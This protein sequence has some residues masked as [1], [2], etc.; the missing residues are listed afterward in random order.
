[1]IFEKHYDYAC[2]PAPRPRVMRGHA[3]RDEKYQAWKT[4]VGLDWRQSHGMLTQRAGFEWYEVSIRISGPMRGDLDNYAKSVL[5]ALVG[6]QAI[7][8]DAVK[9]LRGLHVEYC[10]NDETCFWVGITG[11]SSKD[12]FAD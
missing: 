7:P 2:K 4:R 8:S 9:Y 1:M 3:V 5:D 12:S 6:C 11:G 10:G